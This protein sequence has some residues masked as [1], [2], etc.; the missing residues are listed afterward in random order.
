MEIE[1]LV[2]FVRYQAGQ[3]QGWDALDEVLTV[4][5]E[6]KERI[7][8]AGK[9]VAT[10]EAKRN[11]LLGEATKLEATLASQKAAADKTIADK[12]A[13]MTAQVNTRKAEVEKAVTAMHDLLGDLKNQVV[14]E[15]AS[16]EALYAQTKAAASEKAR[17]EGDLAAVRKHIAELKASL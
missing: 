3:K 10:L 12:Y 5:L 11:Q 4:V 6:A 7:D 8:A 14:V 2:S 9:E 17:A 16:L 13:D 1:Q 15:Q